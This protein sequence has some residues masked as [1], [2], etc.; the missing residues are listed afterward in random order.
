M[1]HTPPAYVI[2][3]K[4]TKRALPPPGRIVAKTFRS[5]LVF[6]VSSRAPPR[7]LLIVD[8]SPDSMYATALRLAGKS[9]DHTLYH[10]HP[11]VSLRLQWMGTGRDGESRKDR[12][13]RR[14]SWEGEV[15]RGG[16]SS[17]VAAAAAVAECRCEAQVGN[18]TERRARL[19]HI[20]FRDM[21]RER[22]NIRE[23]GPSQQRD[24][25][26]YRRPVRPFPRT[27]STDLSIC[28]FLCHV[29]QGFWKK[30]RTSPPSFA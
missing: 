25:S 12:G 26:R 18:R 4:R 8:N 15:L 28:R 22:I 13:E 19:V 10:A 14:G 6:I 3:K 1:P 23:Q 2:P 17:G 7:Y 16:N 20:I 5:T 24:P 30:F 21:T 29:I 11:K 9:A 27:Q